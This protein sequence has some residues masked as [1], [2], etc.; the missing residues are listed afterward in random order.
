VRILVCVKQVPDTEASLSIDDTTLWIREDDRIAFRMNRYDEYAL[1]EA[2]LIREA[3]GDVT[4]DAISVGP[5][6]AASVLK[7][8]LEKGAAN[9]VH[10]VRE[11]PDYCP[12]S[13]TAALIA[14]YARSNSYDLIFTGVMA[15]DDMQCQV[16]PLVAAHLGLPCAVSVVKE[17][18]DPA[19]RTI[20]VECEIEGGAAET[21]TLPLPCLVSIQ[22]GINRPRY[23]SLS[24]VLRAKEQV[25]VRVAPDGVSAPRNIEKALSISHPARSSRGT[26]IEG[27]TEQKAEKLLAL[28]H[29]KSLL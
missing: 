5:A 24:N 13:V 27:S 26:V 28:L 21:V 18:L 17:T 6:R 19:E 7:K 4:V 20:T 22:S 9:A 15:E 10:I 11:A 2:V 12:P 14:A 23:P 16:G 3:L 8:S 1:E 25:L 29:E